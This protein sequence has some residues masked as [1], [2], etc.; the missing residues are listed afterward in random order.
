MTNTETPVGTS[1]EETPIV[2][3]KTKDKS[4]PVKEIL[5]SLQDQVSLEMLVVLQK[6]SQALD[7]YIA[8]KQ[9]PVETIPTKL[10]EPLPPHA[11]KTYA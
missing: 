8:S 3:T 7:V 10:A 9:V 2:S 6:A 1:K 4:G 11:H 5:P